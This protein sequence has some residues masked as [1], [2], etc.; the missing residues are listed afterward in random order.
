[1]KLLVYSQK[2]IEISLYFTYMMVAIVGPTASHKSD[3]AIEVAKILDADIIN[4]DAYQMY[5]EL[6]IGVNKPSSEELKSVTHHFISNLSIKERNNIMSFQKKARALIDKLLKEK[7]NIVLVGGSGLYLR[8]ILFDYQFSEF[9]RGSVDLKEYEKLDDVALHKALEKIDL[10]SANKIHF[11]N[12]R[13]VLRAIEIYLMNGKTKSQLEKEQEHKMI[14]PCYI[15]GLDIPREELYSRIEK[16]VDLMVKHGLVEEVKHLK[17]A[18]ES[19]LRKVDAIG[20]QEILRYLEEEISLEEALNIMK[21]KTKKYAKRQ[22]T[23]FTHQFDV[24][25]VHSLKEGKE[26][27]LGLKEHG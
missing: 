2:I 5:E 20:Y 23:F 22:M 3:L 16:R 18:D 26:Y 10:E 11:K 1:M 7:K 19:S 12:R 9:E 17:E 14:Y 15:V 21:S 25:W 27:I 13:R 6:N 4:F 8:A 24:H